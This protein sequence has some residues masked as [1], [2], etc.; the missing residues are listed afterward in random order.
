MWKQPHLKSWS[1][2]GTKLGL[3]IGPMIWEPSYVHVVKGHIPRSKVIYQGQRS[4]TKVKGHLRSSCR[5]GWKCESGL[6][7]KVEVRLE[8]NLVCWYN[9][10][11]FKCS[12]GQRSYQ[13]QRSSEVKLQDRLNMWKWSH[14]KS[15]SLIWIKLG[16]LTWY[17]NLHICSCSQKVSSQGQRSC[18]VNL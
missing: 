8:P 2:I 1:R 13:G 17:G 15:W 6:I 11:T 18:E 3:L 16:L 12:C 4:Y 5:I 7:W 10:G 9:M 14:L